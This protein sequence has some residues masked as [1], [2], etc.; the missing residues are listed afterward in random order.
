MSIIATIKNL[1]SR[2]VDQPAGEHF[3]PELFVYVVIPEAIGPIGRGEKY[4]DPLEEALSAAGLGSISGG[5]SQLSDERPDGTRVVESCGVDVNVADLGKALD[6]LR[7][8]LP[9]LGAPAGT[10]LEY[11]REGVMLRDR[12]GADGW[13]IALPRTKVHPG[14]GV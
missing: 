3:D 12:L 4:E 1:F 13:S 10:E 2:H 14:F 5:G 9:S 7:A 11:T 6:L 8:R